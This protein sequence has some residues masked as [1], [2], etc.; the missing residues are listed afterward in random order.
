MKS[1][2]PHFGTDGQIAVGEAFAEQNFTTVPGPTSLT[3]FV[4]GLLLVR[5]SDQQMEE[6]R[7]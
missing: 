5:R 3:L 1:D 2:I 6:I 4:P 7:D